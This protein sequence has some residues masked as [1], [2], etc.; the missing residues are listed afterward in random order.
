MS[1]SA[2]LGCSRVL[3]RMVGLFRNVSRETPTSMFN[4]QVVFQHM[5]NAVLPSPEASARRENLGLP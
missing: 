2:T 5:A 3:P 4:P 1:E